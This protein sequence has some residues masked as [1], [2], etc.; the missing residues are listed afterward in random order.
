[1]GKFDG[2][3]PQ[4]VRDLLTEVKHAASELR[5][6]EDQVRAAMSRAGLATQTTHRPVQVADSADHMVKDVNTRLAVLEKR[7]DGKL[8]DTSKVGGGGTDE[9]PKDLPGDRRDKY[10]NPRAG[11]KPADPPTP[12]DPDPKTGDH[13]KGTEDAKTGDSPKSGEDAKGSDD[14][15]TGKDAKTGDTPKTGDD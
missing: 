14:A 2:M 4:L 5:T 15:K 6:V 11:D 7:A 13:P 3:D 9:E 8:G 12:K 10:D 1:M